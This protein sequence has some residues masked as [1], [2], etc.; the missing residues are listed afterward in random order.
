MGRN[1]QQILDALGSPEAVAARLMAGLAVPEEQ[2]RLGRNRLLLGIVALVL[3]VF[4]AIVDWGLSDAISDLIFG[5]AVP[6]TEGASQGSIYELGAIQLL[7]F[8]I[9][10]L[11]VAASVAVKGKQREST[12]LLRPCA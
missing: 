11:G 7:I 8:A 12:A 9:F 4:V 10:G 1:D 5:K 3:G 2:A 6:E